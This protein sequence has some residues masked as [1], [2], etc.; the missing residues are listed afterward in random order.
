MKAKKLYILFFA[1]LFSNLWD[2]N[3]VMAKGPMEFSITSADIK[4]GERI[5]RDFTC[6]GEDISPGLQW[7]GLPEGTKSLVLIVEDPD[8]PM[9]TFIH[10]VLYDIPASGTG[11]ERGASGTEALA[12]GAREGVSSFGRKGYNGP[13]PPPGHGEHRYYFRLR[14][15]DIARLEVTGKARKE[16]VEAVM[17]G[18][19]LAET[20]IMG[21]Y[22]R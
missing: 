18:H 7:E 17:N 10:W 19:V 8:A 15:L 14:A 6:E 22:S 3:P 16:D 2:A 13:C 12:G 1:L 5:E 9:G 4:G 20:S 11:L 21:T